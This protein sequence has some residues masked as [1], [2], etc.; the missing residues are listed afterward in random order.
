[1]KPVNRVA[2]GGKKSPIPDRYQKL[3]AKRGGFLDRAREFARMS[4]PYILPESET[5]G[6]SD[7]QHGFDSTGAEAVN[8]LANKMA[9]TLFPPQASFF[10]ADL[11][12]SAR[13][14]LATQG[15]EQTD[16]TI[17]LAEIERKARLERASL[18]SQAAFVELFKQ[19]L[20]SGNSCLYV[21]ER[22]NMKAIP[23][24]RYVV[25]R[26]NGGE[27]CELI[28][29]ESK[30]LGSFDKVTQAIIRSSGGRHEMKPEEDV[31]IFTSIKRVNGERD[32]FEVTQSAF[33]IPLG[34]SR[35]VREDRLPWIVCRYNSAYGEDWGRGLM[36]DYSGTFH[37]I[38]FL[39]EAQARGAVLLSEVKFLVKPGSVTDFDH[40]VSSPSGEYI[41]GNVDDIGV[42]Q[43]EKYPGLTAIKDIINDYE[44][45]IGRAFLLASANRRD[46]ERVTTVELRIDAQELET[47]LGGVYSQLA[48][49][50][51]RPLARLLLH[52]V[53]ATLGKDKLE[54]IILTGLEALGR[55]G[56]LDKIAQFTE[57]MQMPQN[58]PEPLQARVDWSKYSKVVASSLSMKVDWLK[59]D[60]QMGSEQEANREA[61]A[62]DTAVAEGAKAIPDIIKQQLGESNAG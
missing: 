2:M 37:V 39:S 35:R 54:P 51:Q 26:E 33:D 38:E 49:N 47:S 11:S 50:L 15:I 56:D 5:R 25:R 24:D 1:M 29:K 30:T 16:L 45:R 44:R 12:E 43:L 10:R 34:S 42:L 60:D 41:S 9:I 55:L 19:L 3:S 22:G 20:I 23:M 32:F 17:Q 62:G 31:D 40:L 8:H 53:D 52:R 48:E 28:T 7:N 13:E 58:W 6:D 61:A 59:S 14:A 57:A 46:A 18:G 36:E 27:L 21:P 4:L